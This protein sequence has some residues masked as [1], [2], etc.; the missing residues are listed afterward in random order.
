MGQNTESSGTGIVPYRSPYGH[1][2]ARGFPEAA[3]STF[4]AGN[5]IEPSTAGSTS[6]HRVTIASSLSTKVLGV[7]AEAA[8]SNA[9]QT[10]SVYEARPEIEF[11]G[12]VKEVIAS[13]MLWQDRSFA[14]DS[15]KG[16]HYLAVNATAAEQRVIITE[17]GSTADGGEAQLAG[18]GDTNGYVAF[19][20][21]PDFSFYGQST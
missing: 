7:A 10:I 6:G 18:I 12:W 15:T 17:I 1:F 11:K 9:D 5:I 3:N 4:R 20:F 21:I 13:T 16:I 14:Y 2:P 19:R 8:S